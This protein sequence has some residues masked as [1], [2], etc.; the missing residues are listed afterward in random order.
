MQQSRYLRGTQ[1]TKHI[2]CKL[3]TTLLTGAQFSTELYCRPLE[4]LLVIC[5]HGASSAFVMDESSV[6]VWGHAENT[7]YCT[8][9]HALL[10]RRASLH[11]VI[12]DMIMLIG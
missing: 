9:Q 7:M 2:C 3:P 10:P 4:G 6:K 12:G 8:L 1:C 11:D 5:L